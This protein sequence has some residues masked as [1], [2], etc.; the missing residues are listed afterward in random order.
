M[1]DKQAYTRGQ[2]WTISNDDRQATIWFGRIII[3]DGVHGNRFHDM[4]LVALSVGE[5]EG[6]RSWA[7]GSALPTTCIRGPQCK[8]RR[9]RCR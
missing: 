5:D 1:F 9:F 6:M 3:K 7:G 8:R 2:P 4:G